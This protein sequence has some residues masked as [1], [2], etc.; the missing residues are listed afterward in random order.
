MTKQPIIRAFFDEPTNTVSYLVA[1]PAAKKAVII[2][3]VLDYEPNDG[4]VDTRSVVAILK[5]AGTGPYMQFQTD[6]ST[7]A[8]Y[9]VVR[10]EIDFEKTERPLP[11]DLTMHKESVVPP[12]HFRRIRIR[13]TQWK[14][15]VHGTAGKRGSF[16]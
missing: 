14:I 4:T 1:D 16:G 12:R 2:D 9:A 8:Q 15:R 6:E 3:P 11:D 10:I 5:A 13:C 7:G